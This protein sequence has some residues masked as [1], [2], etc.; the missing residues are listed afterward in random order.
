MDKNDFWTTVSNKGETAEMA[1]AGALK[2]ALVFAGVVIAAAVVAAPLLA[3]HEDR[4]MASE[5]LV[6]YDNITTGSIPASG[7]RTYTI[8]RSITQPMPDALCI[9]D[10]NGARRGAC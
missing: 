8:R 3:R 9:I 6:G 1:A 5:A 4:M 10:A 2:A 7:E